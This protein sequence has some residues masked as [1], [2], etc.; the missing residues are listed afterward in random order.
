MDQIFAVKILV[1]KY[2]EKDR[3]FVA[4]FMDL[5]KAYDRVNRKGLWDTLRVYGVGGKWLEAIRS[6]YENTSAS[7]RVNRELSESFNIEV[8]VRQECVMSPW[9]F[10]IYMDG[11]IREMKV[12]VWDVG[13]RLNVRGVEQPLVAGLYACYTVLLAETEGMLQRIVDEFDRVCKRRKLK[14]NAGKSKVMVF[15]RAKEQT[16][17]FA[18]PYGVGSD[19]IHS[20]LGLTD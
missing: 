2:L 18:K 9:L 8:G 7:V 13:A 5:E 14:V 17:N 4:A 20:S 3:K 15:E 11:C 12:R 6:F 10:N 19:A 1:E 16:I